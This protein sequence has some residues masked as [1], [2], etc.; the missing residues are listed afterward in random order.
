MKDASTLVACNAEVSKKNKPSFSANSF[1]SSVGT[2]R[3]F[4]RSLL[5]PTRMMTIFLSAWLRSS[6]SQR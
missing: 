2:S 4:S 6:S 1:A 3:W 5:F